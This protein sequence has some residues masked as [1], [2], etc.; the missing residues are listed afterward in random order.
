M[1]AIIFVPIVRYL[2][3]VVFSRNPSIAS[4]V[5]Q[6]KDAAQEGGKEIVLTG[7]NIGDFGETTGGEFP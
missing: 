5:Q 7:V 3:L 4:L 1:G 2:M 6:A